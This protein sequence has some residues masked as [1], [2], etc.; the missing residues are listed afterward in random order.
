MASLF[1]L[2]GC[3][4]P[5]WETATFDRFPLNWGRAERGAAPIRVVALV[6]GGGVLAEAIGSELAKRGF[7]VVP[8]TTTVTMAPDVNFKA[9]LDH[10][11]PARRNSGEMWKLRHAL[12]ARGVDAFLIVRAHDF[13]AKQYLSPLLSKITTSSG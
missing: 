9:V 4:A 1:L 12:H 5:R 3:A 13:V 8:S 10:H 6:P 7:V 11:V 2:A